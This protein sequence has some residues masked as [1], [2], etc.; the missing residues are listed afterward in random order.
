MHLICQSPPCCSIIKIKARYNSLPLA[1]KVGKL[2]SN[3]AKLQSQTKV[4]GKVVQL[5]SSSFQCFPFYYYPPSTHIQ[6]C[7]HN[8]TITCTNI[9]VLFNIGLGVG[10]E[11]KKKGGG[12]SCLPNTFDF[13]FVVQWSGT[14]SPCSTLLFYAHHSPTRTTSIRKYKHLNVYKDDVFLLT[15]S[16]LGVEVFT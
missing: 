8:R 14:C 11:R 7:D 1:S 12:S 9:K 3:A 5:N 10:G 6:C 13:I 4:V 15:R 16:V 2:A